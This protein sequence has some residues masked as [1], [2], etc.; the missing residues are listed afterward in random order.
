MMNVISLFLKSY[1]TL[2]LCKFLEISVDYIPEFSYGSEK[3][4][5]CD[6]LKRIGFKE[7]NHE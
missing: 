2:I 7:E 6:I 3:D 1:D 4:F 5:S